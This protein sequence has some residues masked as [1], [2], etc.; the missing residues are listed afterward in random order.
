MT[1]LRETV[2]R[3]IDPLAWMHYGDRRHRDLTL[4]QADAAI[5]AAR[6]VIERE[7]IERLINAIDFTPWDDL[8][9]PSDQ[10][11]QVAEKLLA[12]EA[13]TTR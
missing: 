9:R 3:A 1:D 4:T 10:V 13:E 7:V 8:R 6:P 2:A 11:R 12:S 5:A